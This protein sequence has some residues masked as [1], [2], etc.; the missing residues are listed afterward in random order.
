MLLLMIAVGCNDLYDVPEP[1]ICPSEDLETAAIYVLN[2]GL[3]DM[4]NSTLA[5]YSFDD[6]KLEKRYFKKQNKR[7]LGDT[8]NDMKIYG[9][10]IYIVVCA[11]SQIEVIRASD[12]ISIGQIPLFREDGVA[13]Q[14]RYIDF[15]KNKAYICLFD[16]TVARIDTASLQVEASVKVGRNPD[17]ICITNG[18]IYVS[19]SGGLDKPNY[20][21]TV[22]VIDIATFTEIKKIEVGS[23]PYTI[24]TDH[25]GDV[26]V[27]TRGDYGADTYKFHKIDSYTDKV[28]HTFKDLPV[29]NFAING[30]L[31]YLYSYDFNTQSNW[32]KVFNLRTGQIERDLFI[33][34]GTQIRTPYGIDVNPVNGDVY[35]AG[36]DPTFSASGDLYCFNFEGKLK[37]T[38]ENIGLNPNHT[39]FINRSKTDPDSPDVTP[40]MLK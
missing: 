10:K 9:S 12:G 40:S 31:A 35:I 34:D 3:I 1:T 30:D 15:Y 16:G 2:E 22:S 38:L 23:N 13:R 32:I 26:Y 27:V 21:N 37:F 29:L 33:T 8:A 36:A 14:P 18:K 6:Q 5:Y 19:N 7:G 39:V 28:V 17:G 11:S 20:D 25:R 24:K 4:N